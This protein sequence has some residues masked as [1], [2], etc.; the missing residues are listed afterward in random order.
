M[1]GKSKPV[2]RASV[3]RIEEGGE[4]PRLEECET[5]PCRRLTCVQCDTCGFVCSSEIQL[6]KHR[7]KKQCRSHLSIVNLY[8]ALSRFTTTEGDVEPVWT[9]STSPSNSEQ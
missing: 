9:S 1:G 5:T 7:R 4:D 6:R 2:L 8:G 3:K